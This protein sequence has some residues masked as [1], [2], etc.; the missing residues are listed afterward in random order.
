MSRRYGVVTGTVSS[1]DDP[2][3]EG[4]LRVSFEWMEGEGYWAPVAAFMAGPSR[5][6]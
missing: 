1:V 6:A 3:G 2:Q 5:G 4:R